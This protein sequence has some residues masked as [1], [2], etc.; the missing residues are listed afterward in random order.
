MYL[1]DTKVTIG[2][3]TWEV[4]FHADKAAGSDARNGTMTGT[5]TR[6]VIARRGDGEACLHVY[7]EDVTIR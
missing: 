3:M 5:A 1:R 6:A 7:L 4:E 2:S